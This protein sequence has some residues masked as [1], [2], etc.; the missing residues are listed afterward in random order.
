MKTANANVEIDGAALRELRK[1]SGYSIT[2]LAGKIGCSFQYLSQLETDPDR[3]CS[4]GLYARIC[5]A[6][7][8]SDRT[9]LLRDADST[10]GGE[11]A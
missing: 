8:L 3:A 10:R 11:A 4:P 9:V 2:A 5:K 1:L 7:R 6:L